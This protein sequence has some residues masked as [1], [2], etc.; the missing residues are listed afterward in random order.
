MKVSLV[1]LFTVFAISST[2]HAQSQQVLGQLAQ[3]ANMYAAGQQPASQLF[4]GI[5]QEGQENPFMLPLEAGRCYTFVGTIIGQ[6][7]SIYLFDPTG[8]TVMKDTTDKAIM[9]HLT[10]CTK[11]PGMYKLI[12]KAKR[13]DGEFAAQA[14][15]PQMAAAP[16]PV[17]QQPAVDM[18]AVAVDN[19]ARAAF[20]SYRRM[21]DFYRGADKMT[22]WY[23]NLEMGR[24]YAFVGSGGPGVEE[25]S[26]YLWAPTNKRVADQKAKSPNVAMQF[27]TQMG[28][29]YH[30]QGKWGKGSGEYRFAVYAQ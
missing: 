13:S 16:A 12:V 6:Q 1:T 9:P 4:T 21:G 22:D 7:V 8:K 11:W 3:A 14:F 26:V 15:V 10:Y 19:Q 30:F 5:G 29:P 20:P 25:L 18:L 23:V 28:G 24:C 17:P 2:G 27:C